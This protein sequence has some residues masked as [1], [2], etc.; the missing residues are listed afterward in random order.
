MTETKIQNAQA[1]Q[2]PKLFEERTRKILVGRRAQPKEQTNVVL[3]LASDE[4]SYIN[5]LI[6]TVD[7]ADLAY[8][9]ACPIP[10]ASR[11]L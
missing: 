7:S 5:G 1:E 10:H 8:H 11:V 6:I 2:E 9:S 3:F 4:A